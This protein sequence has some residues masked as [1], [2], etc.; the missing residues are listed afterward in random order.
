MSPASGYEIRTIETP[1]LG[2][3]SYL[4]HDGQV[5]IVVD[6]QRDVDRL[7]ELAGSLGVRIAA[8]A[9]THIH[10]DY[11]SGGLTLARLT[12]ADYLVAAADD[13]AFERVA[14]ADGE[15]I[16]V[17]RLTLEATATPGHTPGHLAWVL[18]EAGSPRAVFT[19]GSMLYGTVGRTDLVSPEVTEE[20]TRAQYRSVRRLAAGLPDEVVVLPT[21]GFGSFCA[22]APT[23]TTES[24]IGQE[25]QTNRA[26]LEADEPRFAREMLAG[27]TA[28]PSYYVHM[29]PLN[30]RGAG[31]VDLTLPRPVDAEVLRRRIA[32]GEAVL[33]L[34]NRRAFAAGHVH[35]MLSFELADPLATYVGWTL[36]G[37]PLTIVGEKA[38][39]VVAA[40]LALSRIGIDAVA[41]HAVGAPTDWTDGPLA[42]YPVAT[43]ADLA[44]AL[45]EDDTVVVDVRRADEWAAGHVQGSLNVPLGELPSRLDDLPDG[46]LWVHCSAGYRA[47]VAASFADRHGHR[48][49][50]I[51]DAWANAVALGLPGL[52]A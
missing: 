30:R 12:G 42:S 46:T 14:V 13:V 28:H 11:V 6:P 34:R 25:R 47:S 29:A 1:A 7:V 45:D 51:D 41:G 8:V 26:L 31:P 2:D 19:G 40:R 9:E 35:G 23:T 22:A 15:R 48:V 33:D 10:N 27:L 38:E 3:R 5:A 43:F 18:H 52:Q 24:T 32:D 17:G 20:L 39:D 4:A 49:T 36:W 16:P 50:V 21:H 44:E 37:R